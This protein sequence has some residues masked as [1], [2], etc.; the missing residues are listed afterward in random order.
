MTP[1]DTLRKLAEKQIREPHFSPDE[2]VA[3]AKPKQG[4]F[5]RLFARQ[6]SN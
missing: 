2:L 4:F 5:S 1:D 6:K 3:M